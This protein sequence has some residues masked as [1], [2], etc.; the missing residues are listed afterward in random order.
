MIPARKIEEPSQYIPTLNQMGY[1]SPSLDLIQNAF[2]ENCAQNSRGQFLDIGCGFGVATIPVVNQGCRVIACDLDKRHLD[3]MKELIS[4]D[5]QHLLSFKIGHF[6]NTI[7]FPENAI[8]GINMSM[9][10]HFLPPQTIVKAFKEIYACLKKG[11]RLYLTTSS[12]YQRS[13]VDFAPLYE[14]KLNHE[15]WPGDI[16]DISKYVPQRAHLLPRRNIVFCIQELSRLALK[17][18]FH[19]H[20]AV[21]FSRD[22]IPSDLSLD[23]REYSGLICEKSKDSSFVFLEKNNEIPP[24]QAANIK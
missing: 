23:G 7:R 9:V 14:Q 24:I 15:E 13:L 6:P 3:I 19:V 11:G 2:V 17:F 5:K 4:V 12:P 21:F 1:M 20:E 22:G 18:G 16:P 10:L 8:D